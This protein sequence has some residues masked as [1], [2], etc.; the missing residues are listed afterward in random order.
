MSGRHARGAS[1][2]EC[3]RSGPRGAFAGSV[4]RTAPFGCAFRGCPGLFSCCPYGT[5]CRF[6][7]FGVG[8]EVYG[9][10]GAAGL[11]LAHELE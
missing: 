1:E 6:E 5:L 4:P 3:S 10:G 8:A 11:E 7:P 9:W 2:D